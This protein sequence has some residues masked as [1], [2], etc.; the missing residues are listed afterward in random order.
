[1]EKFGSGINIP[2]PQHCKKPCKN[3]CATLPLDLPLQS[4]YILGPNI[5]AT[6]V[7]PFIKRSKRAEE[8]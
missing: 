7:D 4:P 8:C 1:M 5:W 3:L 2:D 6:K